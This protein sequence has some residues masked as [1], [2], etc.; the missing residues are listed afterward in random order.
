MIVEIFLKVN[1]IL[2]ELNNLETNSNKE[3][4]ADVSII[5][6]SD[7]DVSR[8]FDADLSVENLKEKNFFK[9]IVTPLSK[10]DLNN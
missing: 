2:K 8:A 5:T 7:L 6:E 3:E 1:S 10:F 9:L 4:E